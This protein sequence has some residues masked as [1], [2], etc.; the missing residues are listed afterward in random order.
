[1]IEFVFLQL[2]YAVDKTNIYF[3]SLSLAF[4]VALSLF[5]HFLFI[6]IYLASSLS[7][8]ER[9]W[10]WVVFFSSVWYLC[11]HVSYC[12]RCISSFARA[13]V[14][15]S[16]RQI[17]VGTLLLR[18]LQVRIPASL[19]FVF[20]LS[21]RDDEETLNEKRREDITLSTEEENAWTRD[22]FGCENSSVSDD[23]EIKNVCGFACL[24]V[25]L[26][27]SLSDSF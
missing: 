1:M 10:W 5:F 18:L 2:S 16:S 7:K 11:N 4:A 24:S 12:N 19:F 21:I 3:F 26:I 17:L 13:C 22:E 15:L 23:D 25:C 9:C 20:A 27:S 8:N 6:S 14:P